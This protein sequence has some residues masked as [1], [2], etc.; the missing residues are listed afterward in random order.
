MGDC[1]SCYAC[2][3]QGTVYIV[4]RCGEFKTTAQPGYNCVCCCIGDAVAGSVSMRIQQLDVACETKTRDNVF[5]NV[6]VSCQYQV[7]KES[8]VESFYKLTDQTAQ[9]RS[10]VFD[11]VRSTVPKLDLDDVFTSKEE[12]AQDVKDQLTKSMGEFGFAIIQ[13][14]VTDVTRTKCC[15]Q[16]SGL[17]AAIC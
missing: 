1:F 4:E 6:V 15:K 3:P 16:Q 9:I 14:L 7:I 17:V 2:V 10:Y 8:I 12:I 5:V 11:V 13:T